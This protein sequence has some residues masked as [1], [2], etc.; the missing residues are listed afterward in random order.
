MSI[1]V[2]VTTKA[3]GFAAARLGGGGALPEAQLACSNGGAVAFVFVAGTQAR[4]APFARSRVLRRAI[5]EGLDALR[6]PGGR[7]FRA[8]LPVRCF[9]A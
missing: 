5:G 7:R 6:L 2:R 4:F 9:P 1:A 8:I 3:R